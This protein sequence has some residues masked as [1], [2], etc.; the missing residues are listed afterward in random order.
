MANIKK[1]NVIALEL[2]KFDAKIKEYQ[3]YLALNDIREMADDKKHKEIETQIKMMN[4][5]PSWLE[6]LRK[7]ME[8]QETAGKDLRGDS[9]FNEAYKVMKG[10]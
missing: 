9:E 4:A 3:S 8:E 10:K 2:K 7:L 1:N 6:S 5:L